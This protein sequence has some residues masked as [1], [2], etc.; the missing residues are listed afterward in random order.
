M[1]TR[2]SL[3]AYINR[4]LPTVGSFT[5]KPGINYDAE[6]LYDMTPRSRSMMI[7]SWYQELYGP[8]FFGREIDYILFDTC[9]GIGGLTL[10][11]LATPRCRIV[12]SMERED[13]RRDMLQ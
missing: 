2:K 13:R 3:E 8:A 4:Y 6:R 11:A 5:P 7:M 9:A 12:I 1:T 10:T